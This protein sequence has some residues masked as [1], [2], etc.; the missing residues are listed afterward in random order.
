MNPALLIIAV[1]IAA[2]VL[3]WF[4]YFIGKTIIKSDSYLPDWAKR[5]GFKIIH[6]EHRTFWNTGWGGPRRLWYHVV[7]EDVTGQ[8]RSGWITFTFFTGREEVVWDKRLTCGSSDS[9]RLL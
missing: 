6:K 5:N 8:R 2:G 4:T 9:L 3:A 7:V 1:V